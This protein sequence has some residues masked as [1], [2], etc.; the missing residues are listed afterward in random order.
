LDDT[1]GPARRIDGLRPVGMV[2]PSSPGGVDRRD[3]RSHAKAAG[4]VIRPHDK[5]PTLTAGRPRHHDHATRTVRQRGRG[6]GRARAQ[7]L[8]GNAM[9]SLTHKKTP[10]APTPNVLEIRWDVWNPD[11]DPTV[12]KR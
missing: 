8:A 9:P 6:I 7:R 10:G 12:A 1:T 5:E 11:I 2:I 3:R 4:T